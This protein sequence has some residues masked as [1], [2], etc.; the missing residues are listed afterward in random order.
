M[1]T[2]TVM[3]FLKHICAQIIIPDY[4]DERMKEF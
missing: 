4:D 3:E 1:T 2:V